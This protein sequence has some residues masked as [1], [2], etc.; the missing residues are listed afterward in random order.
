MKH[1][2]FKIHFLKYFCVD[3]FPT[4]WCSAQWTLSKALPDSSMIRFWTC[5]Q[6][7]GFHR[8]TTK[9]KKTLK[10]KQQNKNN[11]SHTHK[12]CRLPQKCG[13]R[14]CGE[15]NV[16]LWIGF[17]F[18]PSSCLPKVLSFQVLAFQVLAFQVLVFVSSV[19]STNI[20]K[21]TQEHARTRNQ[22]TSAGSHISAKRVYRVRSCI[23][24][25]ETRHDD[26]I[27]QHKKEN[28]ILGL[29]TRKISPRSKAI[30]PIGFPQLSHMQ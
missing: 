1:D 26:I 22:N 2:I 3:Q 23:L 13:K 6:Q 8:V 16:A 17:G 11:K 29:T 28:I 9:Q 27:L 5:L 18:V 19:C 4:A 21:N 15:C 10:H 25:I 7:N 24:H 20:R 14:H 12:V 30:F